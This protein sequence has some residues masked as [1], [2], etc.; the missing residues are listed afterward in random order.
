MKHIPLD[1]FTSLDH[2]NWIDDFQWPVSN[3]EIFKV[4]KILE[5]E[6]LR[7]FFNEK[8]ELCRKILEISCNMLI[9]EYLSLYRTLLII[10]RSKSLD[11]VLDAGKQRQSWSLAKG[12]LNG[13]I[14]GQSIFYPKGF[15]T[16]YKQC[17]KSFVKILLEFYKKDRRCFKRKNWI[18]L[19]LLPIGVVDG[20][21]DGKT[22][23]KFETICRWFPSDID[24]KVAIPEK[25]LSGSAESLTHA[26]ISIYGDHGLNLSQSVSG[27]MFELTYGYFRQTANYYVWNRNRKNIPKNVWAGSG[28]NYY[29]RLLGRLV[30]D[31]NGTITCFE[32]GEP[33][34]IYDNTNC[35][36][37]ELGVCNKYM[38]YTRACAELYEDTWK[39]MLKLQSNMPEMI[40]SPQGGEPSWRRIF[41]TYGKGKAISY[42]GRSVLYVSGGF[43]NDFT[44]HDCRLADMVYLEW[45]RY[46]FNTLSELGYDAAFKLHPEGILINRTFQP[47]EDIN[48]LQ[49]NFMDTLQMDNILIFDHTGST[50]LMVALCTNKPIVLIDNGFLEL[51]PE[52][53]K[54]LSERCAIVDGYFDDRNRFRIVKNKLQEAL[55]NSTKS[56]NFRFVHRYLTGAI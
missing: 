41:K 33:K 35:G 15:G 50:A 18:S 17:L 48:Y 1:I 9:I 38:T 25:D 34:A 2:E 40:I 20:K 49:D 27:Y 10:E 54:Y 26:M 13:G 3:E 31:N 8:S 53:R 42:K 4:R 47:F 43:R 51:Q 32:H 44:S 14:P 23:F 36:Y 7:C 19:F 5:K 30:R 39:N 46:L 37:G 11:T 12:L 6:V 52:S 55:D 29:T 22:P 21:S 16:D 56:K 28:H 24:G 45:Q